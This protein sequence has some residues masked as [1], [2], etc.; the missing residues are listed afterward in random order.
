MLFVKRG[1]YLVTANW[2]DC[3][4]AW[5]PL[6]PLFVQ[7]FIRRHGN[8]LAR[9]ARHVELGMNLLQFQAQKSVTECVQ[10]LLGA[11]TGQLPVSLS[12]LRLEELLMLL[13]FSPM[14]DALLGALRLQGNR[15]VDRL[16]TFMEHNFLKEW[17]LD[18]YAKAFGLG[19]TAFKAMFFACYN[20][21]PRAWISERRVLHAHN[22]LMN[23]SMSIVDVAMESGFSSQS[24]FSQSYRRHFGCTPSEARK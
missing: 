8:D 2:E 13:I 23:T 24:Y 22:L 9:S 18:E 20:S 3:Q 21:S 15:H 12:L 16:Y 17:R 5:L 14:G 6:E 1:T 7:E 19:L 10:R 4:L 11:Q